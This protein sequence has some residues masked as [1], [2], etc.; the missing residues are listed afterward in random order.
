MRS[1]MIYIFLKQILHFVTRN[2]NFA[3]CGLGLKKT[4]VGKDFSDL[5]AVFMCVLATF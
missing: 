3:S 4:P 1:F 2:L 5:A